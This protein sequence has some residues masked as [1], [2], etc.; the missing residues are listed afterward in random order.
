MLPQVEDLTSPGH[1]LYVTKQILI[2][3]NTDLG[4]LVLGAMDDQVDHAQVNPEVAILG[5]LVVLP[6]KFLTKRL[7]HEIAELLLRLPIVARVVH[8]DHLAAAP[9]VAIHVLKEN[10]EDDIR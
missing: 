4:H 3:L 2:Q 5:Q 7:S 1:D 6:R 10:A 8:R 9:E